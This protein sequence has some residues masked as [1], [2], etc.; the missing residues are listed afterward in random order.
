VNIQL[1]SHTPMPDRLAAVAAR[2]CYSSEGAGEIM[3]SIKDDRIKKRIGECVDKGHHSVLE[4]AVFTFAIDGISRVTSHQLV[5]HRVASYSQQSQRYV[6]MKDS[7]PFIIPPRIRDNEALRLRFEENMKASQSLYLELLEA[8]I[9]SEDARYV[10]PSAMGTS[11]L[12]TMNAR[13]LLHF[14]SI[15]CCKKAQWEIR[16]LAYAMLRAVSKAAPLIFE[17]AGPACLDG[18]CPQKD[19]KCFERM[20]RIRR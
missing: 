10:L 13:E 2:V 7:S 19:Q 6:K 12:V 11:M 18:A 16:K 20:S 1:I 3:A 5:R 17:K 8:G 9:P 14:F 4:H 15:R